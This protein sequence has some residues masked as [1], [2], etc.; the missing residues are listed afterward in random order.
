MSRITRALRLATRDL[1]DA[2]A[3]FALV[4]GWAVSARTEPRFTRDIDLAVAV[5]GDPEAE[6]LVRDLQS[7]GYQVAMLVEQ[8]ARARLATVRL[9][10]PD[11][12]EAGVIVNLLFAASGFEPE[13]VAEAEPIEVLP[14]VTLPVAHVGHLLALKILSC[15][16][17][18]RPQDS[19]DIRALL[20][21]ASA[22]D[23]AAAR[24]AVRLIEERGF[25]R[26]RDL[27]ASLEDAIRRA[28][29]AKGR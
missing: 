24:A 11:E 14:Q 7:R 9:V 21:A 19:A 13:L 2:G 22:S 3:R 6:T 10:P 8:D 29:R 15:D 25:S 4:G 5:R 23:L 27:V 17:E 28:Q 20:L 26:G 18:T 1:G 12:T 16:D